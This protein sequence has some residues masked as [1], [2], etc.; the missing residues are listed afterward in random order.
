M[1]VKERGLTDCLNTNAEMY[2]MISPLSAPLAL[3]P[4]CELTL[5][6]PPPAAKDEVGEPNPA[7]AVEGEVAA[8]ARVEGCAGGEGTVSTAAGAGRGGWGG[9]TAAAGAA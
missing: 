6:P 3:R 9:G 1:Y 8:A 5:D 7:P 2:G 4:L